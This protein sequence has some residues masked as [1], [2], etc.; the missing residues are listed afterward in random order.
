M[1]QRWWAV[2]CI[3][4]FGLLHAWPAAGAWRSPST[5]K[6]AAANVRAT[7]AVAANSAGTPARPNRAGS[8][9]LYEVKIDFHQRVKMRDAVELDADVYRPDAD[10]K[11]PVVIARTPYNKSVGQIYLDTGRYLAAHGYVYVAM[12]VRGRGDSDGAFTPYMNDGLDGY[13]SIEWCAGQEWSTGKVATIGQSYVGLDQ[14]IAAVRQPPHLTTMIVL[15]TPPDPFVEFPTGL[16]TPANMSW[17]HLLLGHT[18]HNADAI[19]WRTLYLHLPLSTMDATAGF[20]APYWQSILDHPGID[21]YW[22][23]IVYQDK[24]DRVNVPVMHISGW[25]D[26]CQAGAVMNYIGMTK[27]APSEAA[28]KNQKLLMGPWPHAINSTHKLGDIEF[29][30]TGQIDLYA[31]EVRWLDRWLKGIDNGIATE[32]PVR[33]FL[34]GRNQWTDQADWP[35][36]G[37]QNVKFYLSSKGGRANSLYGNGTL[38]RENPR[39]QSPDRYNYDPADPTPFITGATFAQLGGPDDYRPVEQRDDVLVYTS[40]AF[41]EPQLICGPVLAHLSASSSATDTDFT[42]KFLDVWPNGFAQ[43]LSDGLVRAR[44]RDGG[45]KPSL[46]EPG[47]IYGFDVDVWNTCQEFAAG[48]RL[49]AEVASSAFPKYDRNQNTGEALGKTANIKVA[50]QTIYHDAAHPSYIT[51]PMAPAPKADSSPVNWK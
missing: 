33:I 6:N 45:D 1:T 37:T 14:W 8:G 39:E 47:K 4:A 40:E 34:M 19:D 29:G 35:I 20:H 3:F 30:P 28:R 31:Y 5:E 32:P 24:Y 48:H 38:E 2:A 18:L 10:G 12:D 23:P 46:I 7:V 11:F 22:D 36:P 9:E 50:Q 13:D 51:V 17:Y 15:T 27:K 21:P 25:Y 16:D 26:D 49:R 41:K 43:R 44:Y 42:V